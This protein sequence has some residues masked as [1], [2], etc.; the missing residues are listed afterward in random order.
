ML[1]LIDQ[2]I[3]LPISINSLGT[4]VISNTATIKLAKIAGILVKGDILDNMKPLMPLNLR[5]GEE[6]A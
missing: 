1:L 3:K 6:S 5:P 4:K 2:M